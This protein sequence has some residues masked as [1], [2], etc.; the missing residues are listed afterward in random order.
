MK[1]TI[2]AIIDL[3]LVSGNVFLLQL[4]SAMFVRW[5]LQEY[6][7]LRQEASRLCVHEKLITST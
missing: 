5:R 7:Q 2:S 4:R 6:A 3:K 1:K